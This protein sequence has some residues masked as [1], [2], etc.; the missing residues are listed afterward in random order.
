MKCLNCGSELPEE[1]KFCFSCGSKITQDN[2]DDN[3]VEPAV[4]EE[5]EIKEV[6]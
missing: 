2:V 3:E 1:A 4:V 5:T 6:E